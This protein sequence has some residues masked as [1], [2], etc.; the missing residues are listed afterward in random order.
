MP[1][2]F[3]LCD[4]TLHNMHVGLERCRNRIDEGRYVL[5]YSVRV[6]FELMEFGSDDMM[7][8]P[9]MELTLKNLLIPDQFDLVPTPLW[10]C[11]IK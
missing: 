7:H 11:R 2:Y 8:M 5:G 3:L 6:F 1:K 4:C 9:L 10:L